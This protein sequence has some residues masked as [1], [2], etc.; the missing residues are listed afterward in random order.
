[1]LASKTSEYYSLFKYIN[2]I[3][4]VNIVLVIVLLNGINRTGVLAAEQHHIETETKFAP[5]HIE[6]SCIEKCPDQVSGPY[7]LNIT[8]HHIRGSEKINRLQFLFCVFFFLFLFLS[9]FC[10]LV[11]FCV[12]GNWENKNNRSSE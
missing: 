2:V 5:E 1:M 4:V 9:L 8:N 7:Y 11:S 12:R 3:Y 6:K 10:H